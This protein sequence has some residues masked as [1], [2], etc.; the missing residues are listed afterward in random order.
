MKKLFFGLIAMVMISTTS[1]GQTEINP[2][3]NDVNYIELIKI[4]TDLG[5]KILEKIESQQYTVNQMLDIFQNNSISDIKQIYDFTD[6]EYD[7]YLSKLTTSKENLLN[8]FPELNDEIQ[9]L[10]D[11]ETCINKDY[12][13]FLNNTSKFVSNDG[14]MKAAYCKWGQY[15]ACLL[16]ST[17]SG[18]LYPLAAYLCYCSYCTDRFGIC[19]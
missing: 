10:N 4:R 11:C 5:L 17:E 1:F 2:Y 19:W 7:N 8:N 18:P 14:N 9:L 13:Y 12:S 15:A 16:I 6:L 3:R